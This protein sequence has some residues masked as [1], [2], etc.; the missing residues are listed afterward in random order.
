MP[1]NTQVRHFW[2]QIYVFLFFRK[3]LQLDKFQSADFKYGNSFLKFQP[4]NTQIRHF[5]SQ[6]LGFLFLHQTLQQDKSKNA[7]FKYDNIF[8]HIPGQK[9][10][11]KTF[12]GIG[13]I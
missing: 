7:D 11:N 1:K 6:I 8:F 10:P 2:S 9:Y 13:Q 4:Q 3:I 5:W 12:L